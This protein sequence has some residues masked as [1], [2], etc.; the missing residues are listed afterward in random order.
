MYR[1]IHIDVTYRLPMYEIF[2]PDNYCLCIKHQN[3]PFGIKAQS[4]QCY[5]SS[6]IKITS[7]HTIYLNKY[8]F[9]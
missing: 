8:L 6:L 4:L 7:D 3:C 5:P 2:V 9:T 1:Q